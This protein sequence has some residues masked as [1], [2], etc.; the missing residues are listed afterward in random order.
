[1]KRIGEILIENNLLTPENLEIALE[2]QK[3]MTTSKPLG[4]ILVD[5]DIITIDV[6][7]DYLEMQLA[8]H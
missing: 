7:L 2:K 6:L 5:M 1:M 3:N 4:Q 8:N